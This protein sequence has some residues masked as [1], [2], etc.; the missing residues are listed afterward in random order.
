MV[1]NNIGYGEFFV[2]IVGKCCREKVFVGMI[3]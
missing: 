2:M 3:L 1:Y